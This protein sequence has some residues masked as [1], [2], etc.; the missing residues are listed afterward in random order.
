[1]RPC[2]WAIWGPL[3]CYSDSLGL[4]TANRRNTCLPC[5]KRCVIG[6]ERRSRCA[7][8]HILM[9]W[10]PSE[11]AGSTGEMRR[12]GVKAFRRGGWANAPLQAERASKVR[13]NYWVVQ[14]VC[15]CLVEGVLTSIP[16]S[17]R[18]F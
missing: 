2:D 6:N 15:H 8:R 4:T 1:V 11:A 3:F 10:A 14:K 13:V 5:G 16:S 9:G 7:I 17:R 18:R 12:V